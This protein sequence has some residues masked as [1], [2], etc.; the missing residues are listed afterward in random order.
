[1]QECVS[2]GSDHSA[3]SRDSYLREVSFV[4]KVNVKQHLCASLQ[5][6]IRYCTIIDIMS[7]NLKAC[8]LSHNVSRKGGKY[9]ES[10]KPARYASS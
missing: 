8:F 9:P 10:S 2:G 3:T 5:D 4:S 1:M 6:P 7:H